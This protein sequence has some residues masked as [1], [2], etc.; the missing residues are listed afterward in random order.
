MSNQ[1]T[2]SSSPNQQLNTP[3]NSKLVEARIRA[4]NYVYHVSNPIFRDS[5][6]KEGLI[7]KGK[8]DAWLSDTAIDGD[9]IFLTNSNIPND[10]YDSLYDDD[11]YAIDVSVLPNKWYCDPNFG[12]CDKYIITFEKIPLSSIKLIYKGSGRCLQ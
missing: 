11:V 1:V 3:N 6:L 9:V 2:K 10:Y 8:S 7:P 5:V 4:S 12:V